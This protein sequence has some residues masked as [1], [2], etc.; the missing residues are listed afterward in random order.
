MQTEAAFATR[1]LQPTA[2]PIIA[3][4]DYIRARPELIRAYMPRRF[5]TLGT[6]GF[7]RSDTREDLRAF[8]EVD[9]VA[10][11]IAALHA[12][13]MDGVVGPDLARSALQRYGREVTSPAPLDTMS[14]PRRAMF[15]PQASTASLSATAHCAERSSTRRWHRCRSAAPS[16][17]SHSVWP[18]LPAS[19]ERPCIPATEITGHNPAGSWVFGRGLVGSS[20][21]IDEA[22]APRSRQRIRLST[23]LGIGNLLH[24]R[25]ASGTEVCSDA[26][27]WLCPTRI[28]TFS[29]FC[30]TPALQ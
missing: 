23:Q 24:P 25:E 29:F 28:L 3:A 1:Q 30:Q 7:G 19:N 6:D 12:L 20:L 11:V 21:G 18:A 4:S 26:Q 8:F 27:R 22:S 5:V 14:P 9:A 2:G 15:P 16:C 17:I 10:I 13:G